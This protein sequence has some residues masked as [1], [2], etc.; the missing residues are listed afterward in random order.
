M[1]ILDRYLFREFFA[2]FFVVLF[3]LAFLFVGID[4]L[5]KFSEINMPFQKVLQLYGYKLPEIIQRLFPVSCL[6]SALLLLSNLSRQN[7]IL[8]LYV[9]GIGIFR[10]GSSL[11]AIVAIL[12]GTSFLLFDS[13]V[14]VFAKREKLLRRGLDPNQDYPAIGAGSR[15]WYRSGRIIYN[16]SS[17]SAETNTLNDI[18]VFVMSPGF[19]L[20][21]MIRAKHAVYLNNDWELQEGITVTYPQNRFPVRSK[22]STKKGLIP[23]K[24]SDFKTLQV[25]DEIMRL[26]EL[27]R[28]IARNDSFGLDTTSQK[29]NYHQR[30]AMVFTPLIFII[31][32][33][34]FVVKAHA[35]H[36]FSK[37]TGLCFLIVV[38]YLLLF[39]MTVSVGR[40]GLIPPIIA[41]WAP[42]AIFLIVATVLLLRRIT[43]A[44]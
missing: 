17:F 26:D 18:H 32:A 40:S 29:I 37:S 33:L 24:P 1:D 30:I 14:P 43:H 21:Q 36:S 31:L 22:F 15:F 23:E 3:G 25:E 7:E 35:I 44:S 9:S 8:A 4:L 6:M 16:V 34:S 38:T 42:N 20:L 41:G 39:Q 28:Y 12:S 27:K 13:L 10:I 11:I 5:T 19:E 2:Y